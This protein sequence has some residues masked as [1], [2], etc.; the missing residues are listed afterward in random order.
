MLQMQIAPDIKNSNVKELTIYSGK[1]VVV[2]DM[3][4][5]GAITVQGGLNIEN[6]GQES[7]VILKHFGPDCNP[8]MPD[9]K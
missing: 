5:Y 7:L 1:K 8:D 6:T 9:N 3:G 2:K 4:A